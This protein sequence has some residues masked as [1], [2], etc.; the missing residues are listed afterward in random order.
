MEC[1]WKFPYLAHC[2]TR[3]AID[4]IGPWSNSSAH[5]AAHELR[6]AGEGSARTTGA[7]DFESGRPAHDQLDQSPIM[8]AISRS[9]EI[10][11]V[12]NARESAGRSVNWAIMRRAASVA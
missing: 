2:Q 8:A 9:L 3:E 5:T 10:N 4:T 11:R 12:N 6:T 7:G 1:V